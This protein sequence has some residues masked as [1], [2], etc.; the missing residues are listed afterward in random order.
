MTRRRCAGQTRSCWLNCA[1]AGRDWN[2]ASSHGWPASL[3]DTRAA[4][5]Y[6]VAPREDLKILDDDTFFEA[7]G[8]AETPQ[9]VVF[10]A[11][12]CPPCERVKRN[13]VG[14]EF[15]LG[16]KVEVCY[17]EVSQNPGLAA[18]FDIRFT[19]TLMVFQGGRVLGQRRVG[20]ATREMLAR[21]INRSLSVG[22]AQ[23]GESVAA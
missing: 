14:I 1:A 6:A 2:G 10:G 16:Q 11:K 22:E 9:V 5:T 17:V 4:V 23:K 18:E 15:E 3:P 13:L 7:I 19:P 12:T 20:A 21:Y 8:A